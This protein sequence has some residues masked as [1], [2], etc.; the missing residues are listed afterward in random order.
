MR[1]PLRK[2][3]LTQVT[4]TMLHMM[5][6]PYLVRVQLSTALLEKAMKMLILN[7]KMNLRLLMTIEK[8]SKLKETTSC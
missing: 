2:K 3:V 8:L 1:L 4:D 6:D 7:M 5:K